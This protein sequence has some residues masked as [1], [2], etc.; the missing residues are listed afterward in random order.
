MLV[1]KVIEVMGTPAMVQ[2]EVC[3]LLTCRMGPAVSGVRSSRSHR[4]VLSAPLPLPPLHLMSLPPLAELATRCSL[5][6]WPMQG[7]HGMFW[8]QWSWTHPR[9]LTV[10]AVQWG[11]V[12][13]ATV[14]GLAVYRRRYVAG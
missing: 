4:L 1:W 11:F 6:Y 13:V 9:M 7:Y 2:S 5:A 12:V 10:I 14:A 3:F 8:E